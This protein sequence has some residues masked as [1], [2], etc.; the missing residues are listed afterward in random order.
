MLAAACRAKALEAG[1]YV[2]RRNVERLHSMERTHLINA[3]LASLAAN[4]APEITG[5][6]T[7]ELVRRGLEG[8]AMREAR[9]RTHG[10]R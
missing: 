5:P 9:R 4:E 8:A 6:L 10:Q 1:I 3:V 7:S 2:G